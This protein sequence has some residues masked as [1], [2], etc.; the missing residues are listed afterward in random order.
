MDLTS[1]TVLARRFRILKRLGEGGMGSVYQVE[2]LTAPGKVWALKA[3][4]VDDAASSEDVAWAARRFDDE[5]ALLSTLHSPRIPAFEAAFTEGG[6]RFLVMEYIPGTTL[7]ERLAQ[8]S[9]PLPER[10]VLSWM[11]DVCDVLSYLHGRQPPIIVRDLKPGNIMVTPRGEVRLIDF[12]IARHYKAGKLSNTENLGTATYAS[13]EH[14]GHGQT[15]ARSDIYS[16]G[17]TMFHLL[18]NTEPA[19]VE[20]P[21]AGVL[22]RLNPALSEATERIVIRAMELIPALRFQS[23]GELQ[24]A[25]RS[26]LNALPAPKV[27]RSS[28]PASA[29]SRTAPSAGGMARCPRCGHL[30]RSSAK[31]CA[32]DGARLQPPGAA[33][34]QAAPVTRVVTSSAQLQAQK[35]TTLFAA[36]KYQR[37]VQVCQTAVDQGYATYDT[38]MLLGQAHTRLGRPVEAADAYAQA[39]RKRPT[40]QSLLGEGTAW[41]AARRFPEAQIA[42]TRARAQAPRDAEIA[43]QLGLVCLEQG[44]LAQAEGDFRDTVAL[45]PNDPRPYVGLGRTLLRAGD[46][47]GARDA[48]KRALALDPSHADARRRLRNLET[49][50]ARR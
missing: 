11:I 34:V 32:R 42:L 23:A 43:Y 14:H 7:E 35:A 17:A 45:T 37:A 5:I 25:L 12:G 1:G 27:V 22:R 41:L 50:A 18:T 31:Y 44:Q 30:N 8:A 40:A 16:V 3:L 6:Q 15:D 28:S 29:S 24:S 10:D 26:A 46:R 47:S 39:S 4:N 33:T 2:D 48:F 9:A 36:G 20:T 13:P 21:K 38:Y 19:P 49:S